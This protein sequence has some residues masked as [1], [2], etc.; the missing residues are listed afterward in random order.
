M[1]F[2]NIYE[3]GN[4]SDW[5]D[6]VTIDATLSGDI[7]IVQ[8]RDADNTCLVA[9]GGSKPTRSDAGMAL[10]EN[11]VIAGSGTAIWVRASGGFKVSVQD[12]E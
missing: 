2:R 7:V 8:N 9:F 10:E 3:G 5:V 1:A 6:L 4:N 11:Q 12:K